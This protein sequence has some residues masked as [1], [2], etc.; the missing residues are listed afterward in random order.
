MHDVCEFIDILAMAS[1]NSGSK[2]LS[3]RR[4][5]RSIN[6]GSKDFWLMSDD[7]LEYMRRRIH[8]CH[9]RRRIHACHMRRRIHACHMRRRI[10]AHE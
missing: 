6:S 7:C 4:S 3:D 2:L 8:A 9:M 10:L 5:S 1:A